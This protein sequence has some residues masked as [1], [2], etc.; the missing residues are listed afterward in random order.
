MATNKPLIP[1]LTGVVAWVTLAVV[2]CVIFGWWSVTTVPSGS[3]GVVTTFGKVDPQPLPEGLH[4]VAPWRS[5][6]PLTVRTQEVKERLE[7]PTK[8]GLTIEL[9][10]SLL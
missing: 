2:V 1:P 5:V 4:F 6:H 9:E 7:V 10:V 3:V 8:E